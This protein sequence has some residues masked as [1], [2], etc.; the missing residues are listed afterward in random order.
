[1]KC[2]RQRCQLELSTFATACFSPS[3]ASEMTR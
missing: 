3:C 1:M 2:T